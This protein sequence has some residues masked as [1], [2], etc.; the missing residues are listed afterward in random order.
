MDKVTMVG[1]RVPQCSCPQCFHKLDAVSNVHSAEP[2]QVGD[3][4]LC[5]GC[6]AVLQFDE[7]MQLVLKTWAEIPLV[8]RS[9]FALVKMAIEEAQRTFAKGGKPWASK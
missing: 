6:T 5:I 4:T 7:N 9:R 3:F 2:P 1:F 8:I